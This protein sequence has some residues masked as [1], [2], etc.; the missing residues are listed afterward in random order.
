[1]TEDH[2]DPLVQE[3]FKECLVPQESLVNQVRMGKLDCL[4]SLV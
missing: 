3:G 1:M 4:D 2:Q